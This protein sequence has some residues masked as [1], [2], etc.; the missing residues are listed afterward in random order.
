MIRVDQDGKGREVYATGIRN[1]VGHDFHPE[2]QD[3]LV[4]RQSGRRHGRRHPAGRDQPPD[5][6]AGQAVRPPVVRRRGRA[7]QRVQGRDAAGRRDL[8]GRRDGRACG[9]P[10]D[11]VLH[12]RSMFPASTRTRSSRR[13]TGRGTAPCR[14][15]RG[16]W[17]TIVED[18]RPCRRAIDPVRGRLAQRPTGE[19]LGRPVDVAQLRD[20][21]ILVSDDLVGA[22]YRI[23][24]EASRNSLL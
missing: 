5:D 7:H 13:S 20:G 1:S 11:L 16:S 22:I 18:E 17:S 6:K 3:A 12:G 19:Y 14:S 4:H 9:R 2:G 10:R 8:P 15:A 21:S 24:Y 23:W